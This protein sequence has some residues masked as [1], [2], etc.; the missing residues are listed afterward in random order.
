MTS[1]GVASVDPTT[2]TTT[3]ADNI[4]GILNRVEAYAG[5]NQVLSRKAVRSKG[6]GTGLRRTGKGD[7]EARERV[8]AHAKRMGIKIQARK[9][10]E[11][12]AGSEQ[13]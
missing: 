9:Y 1:G 13:D 4:R 3:A 8:R 6:L 2:A 11:L 5:P 10:E 12:R 7:N